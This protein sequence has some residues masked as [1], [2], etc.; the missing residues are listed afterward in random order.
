MTRTIVI[1]KASDKQKEIYGVVL[2]AQL[3]ALD[4]LRAGLTGREVDQVARDIITKAGYGEYFGHGL[5]AAA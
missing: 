4:V 3:A 1:G 5:G 2:E